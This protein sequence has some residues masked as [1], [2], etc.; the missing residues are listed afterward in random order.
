MA[1]E[2]ETPCT[3]NVNYNRLRIILRKRREKFKG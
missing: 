1:R 2:E 3:N